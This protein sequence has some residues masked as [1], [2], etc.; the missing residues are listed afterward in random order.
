L[1]IYDKLYY[2]INE[3]EKLNRQDVARN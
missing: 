2:I 1:D 3:Q